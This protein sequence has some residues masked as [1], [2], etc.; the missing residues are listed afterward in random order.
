MWDYVS[1][2]IQDK[3]NKSSFFMRRNVLDF[4]QAFP[5]TAGGRPEVTVISV[6]SSVG[7]TKLAEQI[8]CYAQNGNAVETAFV[9]PDESLLLPLLN[10]LPPEYDNVNVTMGYPMT[11]SAVYALLSSLEGAGVR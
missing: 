4:P 1:P 5:V 6:P 10:S 3:A 9:L 2:E 7:Q 8:L 11:G